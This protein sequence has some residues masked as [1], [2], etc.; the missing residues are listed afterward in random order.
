[1][2]KKAKS[3][4]GEVATLTFERIPA[5]HTPR[6]PTA[7]PTQAEDIQDDEDTP[8]DSSSSPVFPKDLE[9]LYGAFKLGAPRKPAPS[10]LDTKS[11]QGATFYAICPAAS[12]RDDSVFKGQ[13]ICII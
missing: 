5:C 9:G 2:P 6:D 10:T 3:T 1:M 7:D 11:N 12:P 8:M 4:T 13:V